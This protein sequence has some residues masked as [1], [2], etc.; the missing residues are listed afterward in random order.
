MTICHTLADIDAA[1]F[2]DA[3]GDPPLTQDQADLVAA[4]LLAARALR[5]ALQPSVSAP[6][7]LVAEEPPAMLLTVEEAAREL[8]VGRAR[9][10]GLIKNGELRSVKIGGSRRIRRTDLAGYVA[11]LRCVPNGTCPAPRLTLRP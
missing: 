8:R 3:A 7:S 4:I 6:P 11:S 10:F 9:V 1:A 5:P 2:A